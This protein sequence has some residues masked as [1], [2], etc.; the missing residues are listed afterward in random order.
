MVNCVYSRNNLPKVKDETCVI[1][2]DEYKLN[3]TH[4]IA[5]YVNGDNVTYFDSFGIKYFPKGVKKL[6]GNKNIVTIFIEYKHVF[7]QF[8]G[9]IKVCFITLTH[10][11]NEYENKDKVILKHF[12]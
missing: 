4:W 8:E 5:L 2:L 1:N 3:G 11:L 12:K 7:Q 9:N 10:F 6:I